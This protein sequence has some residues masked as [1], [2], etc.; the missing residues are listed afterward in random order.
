MVTADRLKEVLD[1]DQDT[2]FFTWKI[3][4]AHRVQVGDRAGCK[5]R[6]GYILIRVDNVLMKAQRIALIMEGVDLSGLE[7]DHIDGDPSNNARANL[8][9][10]TH[11]QNMRNSKKRVT[12]FTSKWKGVSKMGRQ[13]QARIYI[14]GKNVL[15][16]RFRDER[17][18]AEAYMFAALE[19]FGEYARLQ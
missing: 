19:H 13:W 6:L 8:R 2:G 12:S 10:V 17:D 9:A 5:S 15:V 11:H 4:T 16:G 18:A 1:Y 14:D 7:V 3:R